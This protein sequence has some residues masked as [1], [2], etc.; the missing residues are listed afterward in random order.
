[1]EAVLVA[2]LEDGRTLVIKIADGSLRAVG[3]IIQAA[4]AE[5]G[6]TTPDEKMNVYGGSKIVGGMRATL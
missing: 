1:M 2:S 6:I 5:W 3:T 4:F